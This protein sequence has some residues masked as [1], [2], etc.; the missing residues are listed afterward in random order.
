[1]TVRTLFAGRFRRWVSGGAALLVCGLSGTGA[2]VAQTAAPVRER[3]PF[4]AQWRFTHDDPPGVDGQLDYAN[5]KTALLS[6]G[7]EFQDADT[8]TAALPGPVQGHPGEDVPYV[9]PGFDDGAWRALNLPHDWGIEGPFKQENPG[10]TGK[11][12]WWGVGWYRHDFTL[13]AADAGKRIFL[14]LD[15]AMAYSMVWVNGHFAGGWPYGYASY[16]VELTPFLAPDGGKNVVAVRLDNPKASSRWYPGGGIYRHVWLVKTGAV[17]VANHGTYVTTPEV[18]ADAAQVALRVSV[19]NQSAADANVRVE[20]QVFALNADDTHGAN[21]L[22]RP[23]SMPMTAPAGK[24][25]TAEMAF[26]LSHPRLW[27]LQT[28]N[29][30]VAVTTLTAADGTT[31]DRYE[32]P[33]GVRTIRFDPDKGF[34]LNGQHVRLNGVCD[35]ADVGALGTVV[36]TRALQRQIEILQQMGCNAIRTSHNPPA[37]ELLDLCDRMG[38][39]VMDEA[40]D[41]WIEGKNKNDYHVLFPDWHALDLRNQIRRDRNHPCV[42]LWST[43][44]EIPEQAKGRAAISQELT[45]IVHSEDPTRPVTAA[46][47]NKDAGFN[48]F[49]QTLDV[50]GF[51]YKPNLYQKFH[52]VHPGQPFFGSETLST[53]S[54]RGEYFFPVE[55]S[56]ANFQVNSY[57]LSAPGWATTPDPE[58]EA[59]ALNPSVAGQ[60]IWTG[61]DYLGEP[62]PY[63]HDATNLLNFTD[64]AEKA[65]MAAEM[66]EL[67]KLRVPSRSSYFGAIDLAGFPK[68][69]FYLLQSA[70]RP[71]QPM[72]HILPHWN[73][74]ERMGQVTPVMV[75]TSGDEAELFLNGQ[76]L[77]RK[78]KEPFTY[79]LRWDDVK[80]APGELKVVAYRDGKEWAQSLVT[81]TGEAKKVLLSPD[82]TTLHADGADLCYVTASVVDGAGLTVPRADNAIDFE[83]S[84]PGEIV[85]TDNGDA[86][87]LESFQSPRRAAFNGLALVVVRT[88][89]GEAGRIVVRAKS[90]GL[91]AA[92]TTVQSQ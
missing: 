32:T 90:E 18:S 11:L 54:S 28:R 23:F 53:I 60:F 16:Q 2:L 75:F 56:Q 68:D 13:P 42:I 57:V 88:R 7:G 70:W 24:R 45:D 67:G 34:L 41:C 20:T 62:T 51:N 59:E 79:R 19:D 89:P 78:R 81:T 69:L 35:H 46:C 25:Q 29:R 43:G 27:D 74:P 80:Y 33:F 40:F 14:Q 66:K 21:A 91:Q 6:T 5:V 3:V 87:N 72:A 47:N 38:M 36:N 10:D 12:P 50:F 82:R 77:G 8:A 15:G 44:N 58:L 48:G 71:E 17:H 55:T 92:E 52:A 49:N 84:G 4:D 73:W 61:F 39:L 31:L 86:T 63:N 65:K 83:V 1:M 85:A 30:Y 37:P 22:D 64:P 26:T 9:R 76:S